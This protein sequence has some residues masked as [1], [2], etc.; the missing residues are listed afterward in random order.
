MLNKVQ[1]QKIMDMTREIA[2]LA[3]GYGKSGKVGDN[4]KLAMETSRLLIFIRSI[5]DGEVTI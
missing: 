5:T 4:I 1:G 3:I 2:R